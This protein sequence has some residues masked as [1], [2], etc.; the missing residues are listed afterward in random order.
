MVRLKKE[1]ALTL[2]GGRLI[3]SFITALSSKAR[4]SRPF[5]SYHATWRLI[6][7]DLLRKK[8]RLYLRQST[9]NPRADYNTAQTDYLLYL[10]WKPPSHPFHFQ[11]LS[12][13]PS[14]RLRYPFHL[15]D[16]D[17]ELIEYKEEISILVVTAELKLRKVQDWNYIYISRQPLCCPAWQEGD[18][19]AVKEKNPT[20]VYDLISNLTSQSN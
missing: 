9:A 6:L 2:I 18:C 10:C 11:F 14:F 8:F 3:N 1:W 17:I 7:V 5:L 16:Q 13:I 19:P 15:D 20:S 12:P 4:E